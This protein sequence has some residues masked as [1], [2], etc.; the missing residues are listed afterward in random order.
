MRSTEC[1][2]LPTQTGCWPTQSLIECSPQKPKTPT[3]ASAIHLSAPNLLQSRPPVRPSYRESSSPRLANGRA[4]SSVPPACCR[5]RP[6][7]PP[8]PDP[9]LPAHAALVGDE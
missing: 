7:V 3:T 2:S 9:N 1:Y 8:A 6:V 5:S 4:L